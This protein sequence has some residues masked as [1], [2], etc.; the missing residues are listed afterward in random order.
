MAK[1]EGGT[2]E[3][4]REYESRQEESI[5]QK[6]MEDADVWQGKLQAEFNERTAPQRQRRLTAAR[7]AAQAKKRG[8]PFYEHGGKVKETGPAFLHKGERVVPAKN[9]LRRKKRAK[10]SY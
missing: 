1:R 4:Q 6:R 8:V 5:R 10:R 2:Y 9:F 7:E 3:R